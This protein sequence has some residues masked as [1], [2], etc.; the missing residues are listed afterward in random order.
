M[1]AKFNT[2]QWIAMIIGFIIFIVFYFTCK[3]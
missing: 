2:L 3:N 1:K